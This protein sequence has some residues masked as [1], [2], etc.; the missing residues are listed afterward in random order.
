MN[1]TGR[2]GRNPEKKSQ[3]VQA[4]RRD[5][6]VGRLAPGTRLPTRSDLETRFASS[7]VT[8][9]SALDHLVK[10]GFIR[11]HGRRATFVAEQLP[12]LTRYGVVFPSHPLRRD[13]W[14]RFFTALGSEALRLQTEGTNQFPIYYGITDQE[15]GE[16]Y[17]QL[18]HDIEGSRLAGLIFVAQSS[19]MAQMNLVRHSGIP[20]VSIVESREMDVPRIRLDRQS[21]VDK[22]LDYFQGEGCKRLALLCLQGWLERDGGILAQSLARRGME[23]RDY[24]TLAVNP[25]P[26]EGVRNVTQLL[27]RTLAQEPFDALLIADDNLVE[28]ASAGLLASGAYLPEKLKVVAHANLPTEQN[29]LLPFLR[30]G[31]DAR[32]IL[33]ECVQAIGR[34]RLGSEVPRNI[35]LPAVFENELSEVMGAS[36]LSS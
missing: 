15:E 30:L 8:V 13:E 20:V 29:G 36:A 19:A 7:P 31:Y 24:W 22:A 12:H 21:F 27:M 11:V 25:G 10:D 32:L 4:L 1:A 6:L 2:R 9:Q 23:T 14:S 18:Q 3:I 26:M 5:I 33:G 34:M 16:A 17:R 35:F 28:Q